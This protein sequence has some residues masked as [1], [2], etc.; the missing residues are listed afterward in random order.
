[1]SKDTFSNEIGSGVF[2]AIQLMFIA[3]KLFGFND[4]TWWKVMLPLWI[5]LGLTLLIALVGIMMVRR[6]K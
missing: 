3:S 1:M 4:W 5:A 2:W 6:I